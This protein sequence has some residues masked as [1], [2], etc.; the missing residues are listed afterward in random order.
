MTIISIKQD[1]IEIEF[2]LQ[3]FELHVPVDETQAKSRSTSHLIIEAKDSLNH[4]N[5][6]NK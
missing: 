1:E 6:S 4:T 5:S 3:D 2:H